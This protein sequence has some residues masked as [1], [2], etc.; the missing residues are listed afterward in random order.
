MSHM[1]YDAY[2]NDFIE[3]FQMKAIERKSYFHQNMTVY[4]KRNV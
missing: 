3:Q 1:S 4:K 2:S